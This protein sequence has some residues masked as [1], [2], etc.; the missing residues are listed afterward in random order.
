MARELDELD[1]RAEHEAL[2]RALRIRI[3][4]E[5]KSV[6]MKDGDAYARINREIEAIKTDARAS[7][8]QKEQP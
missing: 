8:Q 4:N 5:C 7:K 6:R 3:W 2:E 1:L